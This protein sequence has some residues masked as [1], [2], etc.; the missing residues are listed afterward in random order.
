MNLVVM[1]NGCGTLFRVLGTT[2]SESVSMLVGERSDFWPD[3]YV[4]PQ[5]GGD[6][7]G[8]HEEALPRA[9]QTTS[10]VDLTAEELFSALHGLGLP[11]EEKPSAAAVV[12]LFMTGKIV[13]LDAHDVLGTG[14]CAINSITFMDGTHLFLGASA[15]GAVAYRLVRAPSYAQR[16]L[17][18]QT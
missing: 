14:R 18:E 10:I 7:V 12:A 16:V 5:C 1:C 11:N 9:Y 4:C 17:Q 8:Q 3:K 2:D 6:A 13:A 15:H